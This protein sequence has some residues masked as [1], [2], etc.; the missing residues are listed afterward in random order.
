[1]QPWH[2]GRGHDTCC[3][4]IVS[5]ADRELMLRRSLPSCS[6]RAVAAARILSAHS[7]AELAGRSTD[8]LGQWK[9]PV[10][11]INEVNLPQLFCLCHRILKSN[12][13]TCWL[14]DGQARGD[15]CRCLTHD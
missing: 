9:K 11:P 8:L 12:H 2:T 1:M 3:C 7:A 5:Q 13:R 15:P 4:C 6:P 14:R 10:S